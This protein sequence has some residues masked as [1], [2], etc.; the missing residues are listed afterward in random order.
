WGAVLAAVMWHEGTWGSEIPWAYEIQ[1]AA[2][3]TW[4]AV[5]PNLPL[6]LDR[7]PGRAWCFLRLL[8]LAAVTP[9]P[10]P[11]EK[12]P[13]Q[14]VTGLSPERRDWGHGMAVLLLALPVAVR[15]RLDR[16]DGPAGSWRTLGLAGL[17]ALLAAVHY[18]SVECDPVRL[19]WQRDMYLKL[20]NHTA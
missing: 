9:P 20:F 17:A 2:L 8:A 3:V 4:L 16:A 1:A 5:T 10:L 18:L 11:L 14:F 19:E 7:L 6:R 15:A 12:P 13:A